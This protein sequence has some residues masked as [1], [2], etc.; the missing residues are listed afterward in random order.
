MP[1]ATTIS[2]R[3]GTGLSAGNSWYLTDS[4]L[5][6]V[7]SGFKA[8]LVDSSLGDATSWSQELAGGVAFMVC[9]HNVYW[10]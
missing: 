7:R 6:E 2:I 9:E 10:Y 5:D 1:I 4:V 8:G 3:Q